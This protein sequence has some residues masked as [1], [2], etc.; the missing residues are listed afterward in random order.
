MQTIILY[1][2]KSGAAGECAS[3]LAEKLNCPVCDLTQPLPSLQTFD[4]IIIG[5]GVHMGKIYRPALNF[6]RRSLPLLL[7]K[8]TA[9]FFC[10]AYPETLQKTIAKNIPEELVKQAICI[11]SF[12]GRPPFTS[13]PL[14]CWLNS[15]NLQQF[16][17]TIGH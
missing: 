9:L 17:E 13:S 8:K 7:T 2:T 15:N 1:A 14:S 10:N 5:S 3:L 11:Q 16:A 4:T 6:I 12:G